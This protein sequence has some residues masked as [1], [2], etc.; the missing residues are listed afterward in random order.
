[1][2]LVLIMN[3]NIA[4]VESIIHEGTPKTPTIKV[5]PETG[6]I[7]IEGRSNPENSAKFYKPLIE[8]FDEYIKKP[9]VSTEMH[10]RLEHFNTSSSKCI[11]DVFKRVKNLKEMGVPYLINW[12]Y[13]DDDEEMLETI[14]IYEHLTKLEFNKIPVPEE[15]FG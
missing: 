12:Y 5:N 8:W 11:L 15:K 7:L 6:Q 13:E 1:M 3:L 10:I 14:E 2:I 9:A 4:T